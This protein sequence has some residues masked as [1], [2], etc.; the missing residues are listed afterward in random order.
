MLF[1]AKPGNRREALNRLG[2]PIMPRRREWVICGH[3][4]ATLDAR[5]AR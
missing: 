1:A 2:V 3:T 5:T 4:G